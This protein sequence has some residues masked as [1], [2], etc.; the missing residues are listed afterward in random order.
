[1]STS[2][3][4]EREEMAVSSTV[5]PSSSL[6]SLTWNKLT[7]SLGLA[8]IFP[9]A[10]A[11]SMDAAASAATTS[12]STAAA[13]TA[14]GAATQAASGLTAEELKAMS[15]AIADPAAAVAKSK[16]AEEVAK[17][18]AEWTPPNWY[19]QLWIDGLNVVHD[20]TGLPWWATIG[21][22]GVTLRTL[23]I[24][25][26]RKSLITSQALIAAQPEIAEI[27][28]RMNGAP[29]HE[30]Q[31]L[32][33][34]LMKVLSKYKA[35]PLGALIPALASAP[36]FISLFFSMRN[37][38]SN[39]AYVD[40]FVTGGPAGTPWENLMITDN[41][42]V[43]PV[44]VGLSALAIV[45]V[46]AMTSAQRGVPVSKAASVLRNVFRGVSIITIPFMAQFQVGLFFFWVPNNIFSI[47]WAILISRP[48][49][50]KLLGVKLAAQMREELKDIPVATVPHVSLNQHVPSV[51]MFRPKNPPPAK[52]KAM[53]K[54]FRK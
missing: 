3:A 8:S 33:V 26:L 2:I 32:N 53:P 43:L 16:A 5:S 12:T 39:P 27:K 41:T 6:C 21:L 29:P 23:T 9:I 47:M 11:E 40:Q 48:A 52:G 22:A 35:S 49:F 46:N 50:L 34:E 54:A 25:L 14:P 7:S 17:Y 44:C 38:L 36:I 10:F 42:W 18:V 19:I 20:F 15:D 4:K 30:Q 37:M 31:R 13:S 45:E 1:M 24:P 28:E 51:E